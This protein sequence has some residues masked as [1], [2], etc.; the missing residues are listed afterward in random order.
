VKT[1]LYVDG[2]ASRTND[3]NLQVVA[4]PSGEMMAALR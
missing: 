2:R 1:T 4:L 3:L